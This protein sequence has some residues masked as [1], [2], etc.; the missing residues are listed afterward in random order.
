MPSV[1]KE[2]AR[3]Q[4]PPPRRPA[5]AQPDCVL[6]IGFQNLPAAIVEERGGTLH[7]LIQG[8]PQFWVDDS[9]QLKTQETELEVRV[10]NIVRVESEEEDPVGEIPT[11]R[12]GLERLGTV[13]NEDE[14]DEADADEEEP[15][16]DEA[17]VKK[18][19]SFPFRGLI[20]LLLAA[21]GVCGGA[22]V[23][24]NYF[25]TRFV[26][27]AWTNAGKQSNIANNAS[28][29]P[30][31][32]PDA[33]AALVLSP[34]FTEL[35]RLPGVEPFLQPEVAKRLDLSPEQSDAIQRLQ[36]ITQM[37]V[38]DLAKYWGDDRR[39]EVAQKQKALLDEARQQALQLLT[40]P[41]RELWIT[42]AR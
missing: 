3:P 19:T 1:D 16:A 10:F 38:A 12:I 31:K 30:D 40:E 7:V 15:E 9:G 11:F 24:Q 25:S 34:A 18:T 14:T 13:A 33:N 35:L 22:W 21:C 2:P 5:R 28:A 32:Q 26:F 20:L 17:Q 6:N 4:N 36:Q 29:G 27:P 37:A 23:G 41:Q 39:L 8:S 42:M